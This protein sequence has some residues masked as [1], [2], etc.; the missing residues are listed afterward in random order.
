MLSSR[1]FLGIVLVVAAVNL[2][3][4][5]VQR[6]FWVPVA[7]PSSSMEPTV[8]AGDRIFVRRTHQS[9]QQLARSVERG[10]VIVL[11]APEEGHP[12]VVKRVVA[13]PGESIQAKD[14][15]IA[16]DDQQVLDETYLANRITD[17]GTAG[18]DS[19]D[20]NRT[21]LTG[22]E[23]YVMG[24]NRAHS[25]DS[26]SYGP[27]QLAD[28]VGTISLRFWPPGRFGTVTGT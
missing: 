1:T 2:A 27:I 14:G 13:L 8:D 28:V 18:A 4:F 23:L 19:V 24:D 9:Q 26:R 21:E 7:I 16:I 11:R 25:I 12:L 20:I 6:L 22:T 3:A 17:A 15:I 5:G 10:D